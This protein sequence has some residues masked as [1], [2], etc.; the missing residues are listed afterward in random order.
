MDRRAVFFA[1]AGLLS[2]I[3]VPVTPS[4][5][6]WVPATVAGVYALLAAASLA[7]HISRRR[8]TE[9]NRTAR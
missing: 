4:D 3:L 9:I 5:L 6:R 7:D 8:E 2:L 1:I